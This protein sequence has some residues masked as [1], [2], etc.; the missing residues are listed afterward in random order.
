[1]HFSHKAVVVTGFVAAWF[2]LDSLVRACMANRAFVWCSAFSFFIYALHEPL[3][4]IV[5][6]WSLI[7][8][9]TW[10]MYRIVT[11]VGVSTATALFCIA[12]GWLFRTVLPPVYSILTG[13]RGL[14]TPPVLAKKSVAV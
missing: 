14:A 9:K 4:H 12:L 11:Y 2:G 6:Q 1:M 10:S 3:L 5:M 13:D 8:T 7:Y